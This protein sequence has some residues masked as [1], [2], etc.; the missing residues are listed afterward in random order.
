[1]LLTEILR[2]DCVIVPLKSQGKQEAIF[3]MV[4]LLCDRE[5][6]GFYQRHGMMP[7]SGMMLRNYDRQS[8]R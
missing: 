5:L 2:P 4:D 8:G 3:E 7:A 1:M 6:Q